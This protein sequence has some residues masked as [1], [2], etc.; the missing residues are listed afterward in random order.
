MF[1]RE[2]FSNTY[3]TLSYFWA[4]SLANLPFELVY[5]TVPSIIIF[6]GVGLNHNSSWNFLFNIAIVNS[7]FFC[8]A[9]YGLFYSAVIPK[10]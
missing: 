8:A 4:R 9:S 6:W 10:L 7:V 2:R 1:L 5:P 3:S